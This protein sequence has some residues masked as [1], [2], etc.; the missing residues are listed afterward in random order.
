MDYEIHSVCDFGNLNHP[1]RAFDVKCGTRIS[2][3]YRLPLKCVTN[4]QWLSSGKG[5]NQLFLHSR[6]RIIL[7]AG[8]W[9]TPVLQ[10]LHPEVKGGNSFAFFIFTRTAPALQAAEEALFISLGERRDA[11]C[12]GIPRA[13]RGSAFMATPASAQSP[14][15]AGPAAQHALFLAG[16]PFRQLTALP[17]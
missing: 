13:L 15:G 6:L 17:L 16:P 10:D 8:S 9:S 3:T 5:D 1:R 12:I 11:G 4:M 14:S 2:C 7:R